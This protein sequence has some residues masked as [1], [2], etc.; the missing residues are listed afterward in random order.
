[1]PVFI[2]WYLCLVAQELLIKLDKPVIKRQEKFFPGIDYN[3]VE[4]DIANYLLKQQ[5][6]WYLFGNQL[7]KLLENYA[8][9]TSVTVTNSFKEKSNVHIL[10]KTENCS[11]Y[12]FYTFSL[13][14]NS[15]V[16]IRAFKEKLKKLHLINSERA[17]PLAGDAF[18]GDMI[19]Q[20]ATDTVSIIEPTSFDYRYPT[21]EDL[22][23]LGVLGNRKG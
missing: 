15:E 19:Y 6:L 1:M 4:K 10:A 23:L 5:A 20:M 8:V 14:S 22:C 18:I 9:L 21:L 12:V 16:T 2:I 17:T 7:P 13:T 3:Q 11:R